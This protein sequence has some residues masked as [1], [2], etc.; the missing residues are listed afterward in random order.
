[1][2]EID[3]RHPLKREDDLAASG[4]PRGKRRS[5]LKNRLTLR[6]EHNSL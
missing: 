5:V 4:S 3:R 2:V 1:M 6:I